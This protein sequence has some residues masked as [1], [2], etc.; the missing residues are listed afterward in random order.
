MI[1]L[2]LFRP[3]G[4]AEPGDLLMLQVRPAKLLACSSDGSEART[5]IADLG[6][7][8]D[9]IQVDLVAGYIYWTNMGADFAANDGTIERS[10]LDGSDRTLLIGNGTITT[11]KQITLD[12]EGGKLYWCDREGMRVMRASVD[13]TCVE[14]LLTRGS[15]EEDAK[16]ERRHC[17]GIALDAEKRLVYWTQKGPSNGG[18][19]CIFR[20]SMDVP[21]GCGPND[22]TDVEQLAAGLPEPIDLHVDASTSRLYWTD[23]GKG[24]AGNTLNRA[25]I[26]EGGI[27]PAEVIATGFF[28]AIGLAIDEVRQVA[29]VSDL[30][31]HIR[32][33][34]LSALTETRIRHQGPTTGLALATSQ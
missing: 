12:R 9:G 13:G 34:D 11:P 24:D 33:I 10:Q 6:N 23:R 25:A 8:P 31:G 32:R 21:A 16:D 5:V 29:F 2:G 30:G 3:Q 19:G 20:M 17:V 14:T 27:G 22:R 28:E 4:A 1:D 18:D 15:G 7:T 26:G